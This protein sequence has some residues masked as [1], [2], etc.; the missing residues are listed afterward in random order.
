MAP[1]LVEGPTDVVHMVAG[2]T[3]LGA[4]GHHPG[5][6]IQGWRGDDA[7]LVMARF[8]PRIGEQDE[9]PLDGRLGQG[10][11]KRT[12][13]VIVDT[14][15]GQADGVD[16]RQQGGYPIDER[17]AADE[18]DFRMGFRL[19]RQMFAGAKSDLQPDAVRRAAEQ[20]NRIDKGAVI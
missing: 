5:Q 18:I 9:G 8:R 1:K 14:D 2:K 13:I 15:V 7:T 16:V 10:G 6:G 20:V 19:G 17:L 12:R 11:E 4:V 3:Q